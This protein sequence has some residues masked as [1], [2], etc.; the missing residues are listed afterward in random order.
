MVS[1]EIIAHYGVLVVFLNVLGASLGLPLPVIPTLITIGASSAIASPTVTAMLPQLAIILG[2]AVTGG[3]LGDLVWFHGG[4]RY[5]ERTLYTV[6]S[7][8]LSRETCIARTEN[9]FSRWGV[10]LLIV[11]RFIPGLSLVSVPLCGAMAVRLRSFLWHDCAGVALWASSGLIIGGVFASQIE[12]IF[13]LLSEL[14]W[15]ALVIIGSALPLYIVYRYWRRA[16]VARALRK[17]QIGVDS[18]R[19][20]LEH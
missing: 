2:A 1:H 18:L 10:R 5:G 15:R 13:A 8:S 4:K 3:I 11:A 20:F 17:T 9:F 19:E 16:M 6:C 7:L 12:E 14:G